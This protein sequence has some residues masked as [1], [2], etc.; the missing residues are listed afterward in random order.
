M[1]STTA[2]DWFLCGAR[3]GRNL[4]L[5]LWDS[6]LW[7]HASTVVTKG[8]EA[9]RYVLLAFMGLILC[10]ALAFVYLHKQHKRPQPK[11]SSGAEGLGMGQWQENA[12][13]GA[14]SRGY[15]LK[16]TLCTKRCRRSAPSAIF[17][18]TQF[19]AC[20]KEPTTLAWHWYPCEQGTG[21]EWGEH[22]AGPCHHD[23]VQSS[24]EFPSPSFPGRKI[25][26]SSLFSLL[27]HLL[28]FSFLFLC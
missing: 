14:L 18:P 20:R 28:V 7:S 4:V 6:E 15:N 5:A 26:F 11:T 3:A 17:L 19:C 23:D 2:L 21:D 8:G 22:D 25:N 27:L 10:H 24:M 12:A 13:P 1:V 9:S 16:A